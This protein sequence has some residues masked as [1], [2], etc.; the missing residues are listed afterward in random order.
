MNT[1][2]AAETVLQNH[3]THVCVLSYDQGGSCYSAE[4]FSG[5]SP[6]KNTTSLL[7]QIYANWVAILLSA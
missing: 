6:S 7:V 4:A 3:R 1:S 5:S 2:R